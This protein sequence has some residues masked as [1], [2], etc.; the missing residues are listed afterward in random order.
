MSEWKC[1][2]C[3][4]N[5]QHHPECVT[6]IVGKLLIKHFPAG[7]CTD[8]KSEAFLH[9]IQE[10]VHGLL[11]RPTAS[12]TERA[13]NFCTCDSR[14]GEQHFNDCR[15]HLAMAEFAAIRKE[16]VAPFIAAGLADE[17]GKIRPIQQAYH[18]EGGTCV[19]HFYDPEHTIK[20]F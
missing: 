19:V 3:D 11:P 9:D 2:Y 6:Q 13:E 17:Q 4:G 8:E 1:K 15:Y 10:L 20:E 5:G 7:F 14:Y 16:A 12:D 18:I